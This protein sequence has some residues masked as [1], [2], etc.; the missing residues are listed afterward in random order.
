MQPVLTYLDFLDRK[1][2][3][4]GAL[5]VLVIPVFRRLFFQQD[6]KILTTRPNRDPLYDIFKGIA[7]LCVILIHTVDF[8]RDYPMGSDGTFGI[9]LLNNLARFAIPV[10]VIS[11]GILLSPLKKGDLLGFYRRKI[12][13]IVVPYVLCT[14]LFVYVRTGSFDGFWNFLVTGTTLVPYYFIIMLFQLY[15]IY[16]FIERFRSESWFLPVAFVISFIS[17]FI[18]LFWKIGGAE[19]FGQ[20]LFFFAFGIAKR[21]SFLTHSFQIRPLYPLIL[22]GLYLLYYFVDKAYYYNFRPFY[23]VAI[24]VLLYSLKDWLLSSKV[25]TNI[26]SFIG[27]LSLWIFLTH[28]VIVEYFYFLI[29]ESGLFSYWLSFVLVFIA[30]T[31]VSVVLS[32]IVD[33][34]Y[35]WIVSLFLRKKSRV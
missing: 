33:N 3:L 17:F 25:I 9:F 30:A 35:M 27:R 16:P 7:I 22:V 5:L 6:K 11:S 4:I 23:G 15:L 12:V 31:V 1:Y 13:R 10:F 32:Y 26:G 2:L 20:Y 14:V 34:V 28:F 18:P 8:F 21:T 29:R 19:F 24:F